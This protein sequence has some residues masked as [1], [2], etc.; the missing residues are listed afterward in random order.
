MTTHG[1]SPLLLP[2]F[3]LSLVFFSSAISEALDLPAGLPEGL[4][5]FGALKDEILKSNIINQ[6]DGSAGKAANAPKSG[7]TPA[8]GGQGKLDKMIKELG[9]PAPVADAAKKGDASALNN[10]FKSAPGPGG[11]AAG[12]ADALKKMFKSGPAPDAAGH[13]PAP[14][15]REGSGS[16]QLASSFLCVGMIGFISFFMAL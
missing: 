3:A 1:A 8:P 11:V 13:K 6:I 4:K 9:V 16:T 5:E 2:V 10:I 12:A 14:P 7:D 15:P